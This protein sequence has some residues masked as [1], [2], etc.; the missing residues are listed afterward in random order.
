[1]ARGTRADRGRL[2][3]TPASAIPAGILPAAPFP[4]RLEGASWLVLAPVVLYVVSAATFTGDPVVAVHVAVLLGAGGLLFR[5]VGGHLFRLAF[6]MNLTWVLVLGAY[7]TAAQ[8]LPF[9][10]GGDDLFFHETSVRLGAAWQ[11]GAWNAHERFTHFSG[12]GYIALGAALHV[13]SAP[14]GE[15][16]PLVVRVW[17][18]FAGASI[19]PAAYLLVRALMPGAGSR[20]PARAAAVVAVFPIL[21]FYSA[22]G[23]RD[24]WLAATATWFIASIVA[25]RVSGRGLLATWATPGLLIVVSALLRPESALALLAF[26]LGV[27]FAR[28]DT[29][30]ARAGSALIVLMATGL[31]IAFLDVIVAQLIQQQLSYLYAA[32]A[33]GPGSFGARILQIPPPAGYVARFVY[34]LVTPVPPLAA[35]RADTVLIGLG[36]TAWYFA[37]PLAAS[38]LLTVRTLGKEQKAAAQG[39][40]VFVLVLVVGVALTSIDLRHKLPIIP[41]TL[42]LAACALH[43]HGARWRYDRLTGV[44]LVGGALGAVYLILKLA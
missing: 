30:A 8:G 36:A 5:G 2:L 18:A 39:I 23:L 13:V 34:A 27:L 29:P 7:Y 32:D 33:A 17:G 12:F 4:T 11:S 24:I 21:T 9:T 20:F 42:L 31:T 14:L 6:G 35:I 15:A 41:V 10:G 3:L 28:R 44:A 26:W 40:A 16:G 43:T 25:S 38:G 19:G 37:L 22:I 1:M